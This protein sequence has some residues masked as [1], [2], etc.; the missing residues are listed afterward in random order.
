M[1]G[2]G[3]GVVSHLRVCL[4][5]AFYGQVP[6]P[7][8]S[9]PVARVDSSPD[10]SVFLNGQSKLETPYIMCVPGDTNNKSQSQAGST[11][12]TEMVERLEVY[13][14]LDTTADAISRE[15]VDLIHRVRLDIQACLHNWNPFLAA[16]CQVPTV[17]YGYTTK[18]FIYSGDSFFG[19][20][21]ERLV[22]VFDFDLQSTITA[23]DQGFG[24]SNPVA[25]NPLEIL[26]ADFNPVDTDPEDHP[27]PVA[28]IDV[29]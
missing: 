4:A 21:K 13:A 6:D 19:N 18:N 14:V 22:W 24:P 11:A 1:Q 7:G 12:L 16:K 27:F 29:S 25:V 5:S 15:A 9:I 28:E 26:H 23:Q 20:D 2:D 17:D 10:P 8:N 3:Y